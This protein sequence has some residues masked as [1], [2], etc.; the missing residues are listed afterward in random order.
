MPTE[1]PNITVYTKF[2][3]RGKRGFSVEKT[4]SAFSMHKF[5]FVNHDLISELNINDY[6]NENELLTSIME[7]LDRMVIR[8]VQTV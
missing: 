4:I 8:E 2:R 1:I 7:N 6:E 5:P 3:E